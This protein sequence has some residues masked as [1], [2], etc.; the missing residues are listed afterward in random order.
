V[1]QDA[2]SVEEAEAAVATAVQKFGG[3]NR[4]VAAAGLLRRQE[5]ASMTDEQLNDMLAVNFL[6]MFATCRAASRVMRPGSSIVNL[7]SLAAH[8]GCE[9]GAH[10]AAA[11][12]AALAF[13]KSLAA[14]LA[15]AIRVNAVSP[16]FID[17]ALS[18][19]QVAENGGELRDQIPMRRLGSAEEVAHALVFLCSDWASK[20]TGRTLHVNGRLYVPG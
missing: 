12:G 3:L 14:E 10:Y 4:L 2:R 1:K 17:T 6:G 5:I 15:P 9:R 11:K 7:A 19:P 20:I 16:G 18:R 8:T 13:T